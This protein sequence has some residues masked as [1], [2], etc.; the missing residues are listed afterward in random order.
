MAD[1]RRLG[2]LLVRPE[3]VAPDLLRQ[4]AAE[5]LVDLTIEV[6]G[7]IADAAARAALAGPDAV[8]IGGPVTVAEVARFPA[9]LPVFVVAE[10]TAAEENAL[11]LTGAAGVFAPGRLSRLP[12]ALARE[13]TIAVEHAS[14]LQAETDRTR[15]LAQLVHA[16]KMEA[17][18]T[19]AGG[20]A[21]DLNNVLMGILGNAEMAAEDV[22]SSHP[23]QG[24]LADVIR[25]A[26]RARDVVQRVLTFSRKREPARRSDQLPQ[27]VDDAVVLLRATLPATIELVVRHEPDPPPV[28]IDANQINQVITNLATN[29]RDAIGSRPGTITI[30]SAV[31]DV[32]RTL[33]RTHVNLAVRRY[34]RLSVADDGPGIAPDILPRVFEPFFTTKAPGA[35]TGLGLAVAHGIIEEHDGA[36]TM[37]STMGRGTTVRL[38]LPALEPARTSDDAGAATPRGA[39]EAVLLV[40]DEAMVVRIGVRMLERLGYRVTAADSAA[41]AL[42]LFRAEPSRFQVVISDLT[43]PGH[44]GLDLARRFRALNPQIKFILTTGHLGAEQHALPDT[45]ALLTKPFAA[46]RLAQ[47]LNEVLHPHESITS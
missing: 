18:G 31:I 36:I 9:R 37:E 40:D 39:G 47:V 41:A 24:N 38:Y 27:V 29:A 6:V 14:L 11:I 35:G 28:S 23:A 46:S 2:I 33:A 7:S 30:S 5:A 16:Q 25:A 3:I 32:D 15:L 13:S 42:E 43:M 4:Q 22:G 10:V 8:V 17:I 20:L 44:T 21:H 1:P 34:V 45:D 19:L 12:T 26:N